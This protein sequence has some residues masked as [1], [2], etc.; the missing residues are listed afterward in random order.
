MLSWRHPISSQQIPKSQVTW[1]YSSRGPHRSQWSPAQ[2]IISIRWK[3][4]VKIAQNTIIEVSKQYL[5][6]QKPIISADKLE[7]LEYFF[8]KEKRT[9]VCVNVLQNRAT[10]LIRCQKRWKKNES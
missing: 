5:N 6:F 1:H 2:H 4:I 10:I 3:E 8:K 7:K 9:G